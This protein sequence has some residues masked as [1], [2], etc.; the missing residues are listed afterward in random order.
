MK[1]PLLEELVLEEKLALAVAKGRLLENWIFIFCV[2]ILVP[3]PFAA[4][5]FPK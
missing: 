2:Y 3:L 4:L 5:D 1:D